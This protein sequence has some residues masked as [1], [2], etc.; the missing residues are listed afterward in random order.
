MEPTFMMS[1]KIYW[2]LVWRGIIAGFL[3]IGGFMAVTFLVLM[4]LFGFEPLMAGLP[5][6]AVG[7]K[8]TFGIAFFVVIMVMTLYVNRWVYN[9]LPGIN[10]RE[11]KVIF[12]KNTDVVSKFGLVDV[13]CV[14]WSQA[15]RGIVL[16]LPVY[17]IQGIIVAMLAM[18]SH[19]DNTNMEIAQTPAAIINLIVNIIN[20]IAAILAIKWMIARKKDG[21]WLRLEAR[22]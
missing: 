10:Y 15:W 2:S 6:L 18:G 13:I 16:M 21:R 9:C 8:V 14:A 4:L 5:H 22:Q 3:V 7:I 12:M 20:I 11:G 17:V 19:G 1:L